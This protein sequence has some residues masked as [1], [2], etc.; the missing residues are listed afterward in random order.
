M[1]NATG[2]DSAIAQPPAIVL[3]TP[4]I[5]ALEHAS[6]SGEPIPLRRDEPMQLNP[7]AKGELRGR[8]LAAAG[9]GTLLAG[10]LTLTLANE[11]L[12]MQNEVPRTRNSAAVYARYA[13]IGLCGGG[14]ATSIVG[15]S[16]YRYNRRAGARSA[17]N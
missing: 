17:T 4:P 16:L 7:Y 14:A 10:I 2:Y 5:L 11:N 3:A 6:L 12:R 9:L 8:R 1:A 13:G 15:F